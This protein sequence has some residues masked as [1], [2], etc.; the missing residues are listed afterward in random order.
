MVEPLCQG[1]HPVLSLKKR[2]LYHVSF[3]R[4]IVVGRSLVFM[5][6][7]DP[8]GITFSSSQFAFIPQY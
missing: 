3:T 1:K 4:Y 2:Q 6:C 7:T 5:M 8:S